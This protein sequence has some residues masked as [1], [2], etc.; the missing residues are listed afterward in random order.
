MALLPGT[1][2]IP[3][4]R[5]HA[6]HRL[7]MFHHACGSATNYFRWAVAFPPH[8]EVWLV[9]LPGRGRSLK[10][11]AFDTLPALR[12]YLRELAPALP[13]DYAIF[14]HSM[15]ALVA[16][17]F[18]HDMTQLGRAPR[19]L[20]VSG[21]D[22]P[23]AASRRRAFP[24]HQRP[25]A[26]IVEHLA[27]L[28]GTPPE[29]FAHDELR[30]MLL[31]L[32]KADFRIVEAFF[33]LASATPLPVP[34]TVFAG[35]HDTVLSEGG[36]QDWQRASTLPIGRET[37]DGRHFYLLDTPSAVHG[38]IDAALTKHERRADIS[39]VQ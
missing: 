27:T 10:H 35:A 37:F 30:A 16:Y 9:E 7:L 22:S 6:R 38:A 13:A 14:G 12:D 36:L 25:D 26:A 24:V 23:F 17:C 28:G 39:V 4:R 11:A 18:A 20:G 34:V 19:W 2:T 21:A 32:A 15:G 8:V 31:Q 29:V 5:E 1:L 3:D 33:P